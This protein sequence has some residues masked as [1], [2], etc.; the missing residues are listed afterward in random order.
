MRDRTRWK[1]PW[2]PAGDAA[3]IALVCLLLRGPTFGLSGISWDESAFALVAREILNGQWP[4]TTIF[5]HKPIGLYLH[6]AAAFA[7]FGDHPIATRLLCWIVT[8]ATAWVVRTILVGPIGLRREPAFLIAVALAIAS[9]GFGGQAAMSEHFA[10]LYLAL[11]A[12]FLLRRDT[13]AVLLA[14]AFAGIA[15]NSS[16]LAIPVIVGLVA[17]YVAGERSTAQRIVRDLALFATAALA[18]TAILLLPLLL[19]SNLAD[20]FGP[21]FAFLGAYSD[22]ATLSQR[23]ARF[24]GVAAMLIPLVAAGLTVLLISQNH[25]PGGQ[26]S[27]HEVA[28]FAGMGVGAALA[29]MASGYVFPNYMLLA[30]PPL[31]LWS[32]AI[33]HRARAGSHRLI[34]GAFIGGTSLIIGLSG[35]VESAVGAADLIAKASRDDVRFDPPRQI[36]RIAASRVRAGD[37]VYAV[38]TPPVVYQLLHVRPPTKYPIN[39]QLM[40]PSLSAS[41]GINLDQELEAIFAKRPAVVIL[42]GVDNCWRVPP[43]ALRKVSDMLEEHGYRP[44][45]RFGQFTFLERPAQRLPDSR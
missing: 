4:F 12:L 2:G 36:A 38:C 11:S 20:Y 6:F 42:G 23:L 15:A 13:S 44:Y 21:Q 26:G 25:V 7:I 31:F 1:F 40:A 45:A 28:P 10:N 35:L 29:T 19:F 30:L 37:T 22:S 33:A 3:A 43:L 34:F 8:T 27:G 14:G 32:G 5:D 9:L 18:A 17:G 16:Y 39:A 41:L 24:L